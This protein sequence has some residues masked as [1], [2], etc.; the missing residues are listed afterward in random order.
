MVRK[1]M[2]AVDD[3]LYSKS[4]VKYVARLSA[5]LKD[6]HCVLFNAQPMVSQFLVDEAKKKA[7]SRK[8]LKAVMERNAAASQK[9]L[10]DIKT[11]MV[12]NGVDDSRI[13][14]VTQPRKLD[15]AKDM[16]EYAQDGRFD[17]LAVGRRGI[18]GFQELFMGSVSSNV[19][20][21]SKVIPVWIVGG[22]VA[23]SR[24][25]V[26]VDGSEY[27]LRAID[28]LAFTMR[29]AADISLT[30]LHV[31]PKLKDYCAI[32][33]EQTQTGALEEVMLKG[34]AACIDNF[35][36]H[37][38]KKLKEFDIDED[39]IRTKTVAGLV[40]VGSIIMKEFQSGNFDTIVVGRSGMNK[41]FFTGSV[42]NT[43]LNKISKGAL[44][45]V[46]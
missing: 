15:I 8:E 30:F 21:N 35:Y 20:Q 22:D 40:N 16:I 33:F 27:S 43:L 39:R 29:D 36:A 2:I 9:L 32:D 7:D 14:T 37:A 38:L 25:L 5:R 10:D 4:V 41:S 6:L 18:S 44:W 13:Q 19:A 11:T 42:T 1:V 23:P 34:D 12:Q 24:F 3:S 45:L 28:H 26:A 31:A 46:P 17:A